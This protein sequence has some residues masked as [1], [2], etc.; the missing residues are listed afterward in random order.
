MGVRPD[1]GSRI[2]TISTLCL[3]DD[4]ACRATDYVADMIEQAAQRRRHD[5]IVAPLTP[6]LSFREGCEAR[7]LARFAELART[8]QTHLAIALMEAARDGRSFCTSVLLGRRGRIVGKYRKTHALPDDAMALGD[9]VPVFQTDFGVLG[10]SLGTDFYFPEVYAV[11]WMKGAEILIW[12]HYPER[13]REHFQWVSLLKARATDSHSHLVTAMYADPRCYIPNRYAI[14]MQ[15]AAWGRSMI[16]NRVG[17][18]IAHT[19]YEDG[20]TTAIINLDK[21]KQDPHVSR[22][23]GENLLF[24]NCFGDRTAFHPIAEP[25]KKPKLP[26]FKKRQARILVERGWL[27]QRAYAAGAGY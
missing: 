2:V 22:Y 8:H 18:P 24:V 6:F 12:Q 11:E 10:L 20:I 3:L 1:K 17:T 23:E 27:Q 7:D 16:L 9:E 15:G 5:L 19:G 26:D 4:D 13:F 14:G 25:W 21:R